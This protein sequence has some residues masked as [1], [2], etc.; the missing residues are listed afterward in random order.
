MAAEPLPVSVV[1]LSFNRPPHLARA[2]E[3]IRSQT[4]APREV[5]VV[6][7]TSPA[8]DEVESLVRRF[9]DSTLI[10]NTSNVGFAAGMNIGINRSSSPF[11]YLT[12]DD[13]VLEPDCLEVLMDAAGN[14]HSTGLFSGI[15]IDAERN[16]VLSAGGSVHLGG[17]Y[18]MTI[19]GQGDPAPGRF[20]GPF[21]VDYVPGAMILATRETWRALGGFRED[22]FVYGEDTDLCLRARRAGFHITVVPGAHVRH[23]P[24]S[25]GSPSEVIEYHKL[26][27]F[28]SLYVLHAPWWTLPGFM[29]R[30]VVLNWVRAPAGGRQVMRQA[31]GWT[32]RNLPVLLRDRGQVRPAPATVR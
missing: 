20:D 23:L 10:R 6:D 3:S 11:V 14:G 8:I 15:M 26:K 9:P 21:Q 13:I 27:N 30:Y 16:T 25:P 18:R 2:L 7:N 29:V 22:F 31:L 1:V 19:E 24:A 17:V 4:R 12:E 5:L 32:L 28:F